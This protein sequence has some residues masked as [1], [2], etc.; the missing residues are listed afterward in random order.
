MFVICSSEFGRSEFL[1][2]CTFVHLSISSTDKFLSSIDKFRSSN[3]IVLKIIILSTM[4]VIKISLV[5][6]R[7]IS[8]IHSNNSNC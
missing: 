5:S 7:K 3:V 1:C 2:A 8:L 6:F 4:N